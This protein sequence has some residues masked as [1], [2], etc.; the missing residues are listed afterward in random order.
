MLA[1]PSLEAISEALGQL[2]LSIA[3]EFKTQHTQLSLIDNKLDQVCLSVKEQGERLSSLEFTL[4]DLSGRVRH[5]EDT[6][7]T[8]TDNNLKLTTK[9]VDLESRSRRQNL[10]ILGLAESTEKG[11][12]TKFFSDLLVAVFG[13][14]LFSSPPEIDRAHRSLLPKPA[15]GQKPRSVVI[16]LHRYQTKELLI[17][18]A[19]RRGKL[20]YR[21]QQ[22]RI[23]E[24]YCP[25]IMSQRAV[26]KEVMSELYTLGLKPSLLYPARLRITLSNGQKKWLGSVDVAR[27]YIIKHSSTSHPV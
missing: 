24:D 13:K 27:E 10:R 16:R 11:Q 8:L 25:E 6:C 1:N 7:S 18:E 26:Y 9:V 4:N 22:I 5:L 12:L 15:S 20:D 23:V 19:R 17:R 3:E 14:E 2:K 21:G